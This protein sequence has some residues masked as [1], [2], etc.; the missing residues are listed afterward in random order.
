MY[1]TKFILWRNKILNV[2]KFSKK[3]NFFSKFDNKKTKLEHIFKTILKVWRKGR[4]S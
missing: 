3:F 4:R 1:I 2:A